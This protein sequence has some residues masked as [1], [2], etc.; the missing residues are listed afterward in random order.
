[1]ALITERY[2]KES[3][4]LKLKKSNILKP[5]LEFTLSI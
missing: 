5:I 3:W 1:M 2:S 4:E